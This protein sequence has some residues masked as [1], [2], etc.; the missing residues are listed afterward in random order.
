MEVDEL[1]VGALPGA[2]LLLNLSLP[3]T[4]GRGA[5]EAAC[6]SAGRGAICRRDRT[7]RRDRERVAFLRGTAVPEIES[8][9]Q[10]N[11]GRIS[12]MIPQSDI[13]TGSTGMAK[14]ARRTSP[15]G[16]GPHLRLPRRPKRATTHVSFQMCSGQSAPRPPRSLA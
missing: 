16:T 11:G 7:N 13:R 10:A 4:N 6:S 3:A 12:P 15:Q 9:I 2:D 14:S 8:P 1:G 5:E